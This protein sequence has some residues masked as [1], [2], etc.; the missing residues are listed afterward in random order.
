MPAAEPSGVERARRACKSLLYLKN[1]VRATPQQQGGACGSH[2]G[3][4]EG[5]RLTG[6]EEPMAAVHKL[7]TLH[8]WVYGFTCSDHSALNK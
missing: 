2:M 1:G 4:R 6:R 8:V 3:G 5:L 7:S